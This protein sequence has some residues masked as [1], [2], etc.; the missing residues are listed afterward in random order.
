MPII[1]DEKPRGSDAAFRAE[2]VHQIIGGISVEIEKLHNR[3]T[4]EQYDY[5]GFHSLGPFKDDDE[6]YKVNLNALDLYLSDIEDLFRET[7]KTRQ[8][9]NYRLNKL[10]CETWKQ[11][12]MKQHKEY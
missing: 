9:I 11:F 10:G 7:R 8:R 6:N 5:D 12:S 2:W 4:S 3:I 1:D